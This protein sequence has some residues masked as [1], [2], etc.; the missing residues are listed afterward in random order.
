MCSTR[1]MTKDCAGLF[2]LA[3]TVRPARVWPWRGSPERRPGRFPACRPMR[4]CPLRASNGFAFAP[5]PSLISLE[6]YR[7]FE[8]L[9]TLLGSG[10]EPPRTNHADGAETSLMLFYRPDMVRAGYRRA[11][12]STSTAF[13]RG[14]AIWKPRRQPERH[15]RLSIRQGVSLGRKT[16]ARA[17]NGR[18]GRCASPEPEPPAEVRAYRTGRLR[19]RSAPWAGTPSACRRRAA[20][21]ARSRRAG[22]GCYR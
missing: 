9:T 8:L 18:H 4:S 10:S 6:T 5:E 14:C 16:I 2:S 13:F 20:A 3:V 21:A 12:I 22:A 11:P 17:S 19:R 7:N 1:C 15:W